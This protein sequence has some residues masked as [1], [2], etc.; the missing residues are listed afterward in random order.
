MLLIDHSGWPGCAHNARDFLYNSWKW[1]AT[2]S[3]TTYAHHCKFCLPLKTMAIITAL[4]DNGN[5]SKQKKTSVLLSSCWQTV[6]GANGHRKG[7]FRWEIYFHDP[8][9]LCSY[10]IIGCVLHN[11]CIIHDE[12]IEK[13]VDVQPVCKNDSNWWTC[14]MALTNSC[15]PCTI[16]KFN[17]WWS[18]LPL[19]VR[20][21]M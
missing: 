14:N 21:L 12:D 6:D 18:I 9:V 1:S 17:K 5:L 4:R 16:L 3:S 2:C 8:E 11:L 15:I 20:S 7:G 19:M 10:I 13:F